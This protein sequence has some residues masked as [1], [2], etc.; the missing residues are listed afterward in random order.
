MNLR[1]CPDCAHDVS[2]SAADCPH[3]GRPLR[4]KWNIFHYVFFGV[5]SLIATVIILN[6][7]FFVGIAIFGGAALAIA[8]RKSDPP[9]ANQQVAAPQQIAIRGESIDNRAPTQD[10][11]R[12]AADVAEQ[13]KQNYLTRADMAAVQWQ[14]KRAAEGSPS[15]LFDLGMRHLVG[16][17]VD[18]DEALGKRMIK[19]AADQGYAYAIK[20]LKT[21][22]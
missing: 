14:I 18:K 11:L 5:L 15:A 16:N 20:K 2:S 13:E 6:V 1:K 21:L 4:A 3:C 17:G 9:V 7:I 22:P 10:Q 19:N 8:D 12:T